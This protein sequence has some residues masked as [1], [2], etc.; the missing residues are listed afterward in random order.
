MSNPTTIDVI[1]FG[2][3]PKKCFLPQTGSY[4]LLPPNNKVTVPWAFIETFSY[5][6][7]LFFDY[8]GYKKAKV[9]EA[10]IP[11][12]D[13]WCP[14]SSIDG[15]GRHALNIFWGLKKLGLAPILREVDWKSDLA[16]MDLNVNIEKRLGESKLPCHLGVCMSVPY[17]RRMAGHQSDIKV[18]ITQFETDRIPER[19]I[20]TVNCCNHLITTSKF[21]PPI[22][23]KSGLEIPID[24]L[25]PGIDTDYFDYVDRPDKSTFKVLISGALSGRK[26]PLG[27]IRIFQKAS[28][29]D[30]NWL[31]TIRSRRIDG[32]DQVEDIA[33]KDGRI[34]IHIGDW[35]Q[36]HV[37]YFY[38]L[39]DVF[40]WPS[41]GEGVGLPPLEVM[42]TGMELVCS[43]N[44]GMS[45]YVSEEICYPIR[46]KGIEPANQPVIGFSQEYET[47]FGSVGNWWVP[48]EDHAAEQLRRCYDDWRLGKGKGKKAAEYVRQNHTL[49]LQAKSV[50]QI[51]ER[52]E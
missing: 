29:G 19:H 31:L 25:T 8:N 11:M 50:S 52:Y 22:W 34:A 51:L 3:L 17:D 48:D 33:K 37:K 16:S 46:T 26:N 28:M 45:D 5:D 23:R 9:T 40:L 36:D 12:F 21:Q 41:K 10:G 7:Q 1:N 42:A 4:Y 27:A 20:D 15:Y 47:Q 38:H 44:S 6:N 18:A 2:E 35:S 39:H 13:W 32:I 24:V 43:D 30:P 49:E 14:I